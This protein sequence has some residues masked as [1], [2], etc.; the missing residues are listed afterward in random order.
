MCSNYTVEI[1]LVVL[2]LL[3]GRLQDPGL[4]LVAYEEKSFTNCG[5][6]KHFRKCKH[7]K[8]YI[9]KCKQYI[10][11]YIYIYIY[12][13]IYIYIYIYTCIYLYTYINIYIYIYIYYIYI[14]LHIYM[15]IYIYVYT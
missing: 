4:D 6:V 14:Y 7:Y 8:V 9:R 11:I 2:V 3:K 12:K 15:Y 10:Y 5:I 13:Y 1:Q